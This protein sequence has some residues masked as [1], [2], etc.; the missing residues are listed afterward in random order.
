HRLVG[1][2]VVLGAV[3][4]Y[5]LYLAA[6]RTF[7]RDLHATTYAALV[8]AGAAGFV[9]LALPIVGTTPLAVAPHAPWALV[10]LAL[11]PTLV[12]HTAVQ[13]ASRSLSPATV[14]MVSPAETVGGLLLGALWLRLVPSPLE[15]VGAAVVVAGVILTLLGAPPAP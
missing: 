6:A 3:V 2:L 10:G 5:G 12:G 15:A 9:G 4:L 11:V 13:G 7:G 1:D 8:Y 14:A